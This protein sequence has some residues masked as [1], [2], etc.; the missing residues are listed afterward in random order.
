LGRVSVRK[1]LLEEIN[2]S[3]GA[4]QE[5]DKHC[6]DVTYIIGRLSFLV[7]YIHHSIVPDTE[8][9]CKEADSIQQKLLEWFEALPEEIHS[10]VTR[11]ARGYNI[12]LAM[13][14]YR[15]A[16]II[17]DQILS[18]RRTEHQ[19]IE[20]IPRLIDDT[21]NSISFLRECTQGPSSS[22]IVFSFALLWPL[23]TL[24]ALECEIGRKARE[25]LHSFSRERGIGQG[26]LLCP[27]SPEMKVAT[28]EFYWGFK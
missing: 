14:S 27:N 10:N 1:E 16:R 26:L 25:Y 20:D 24:A 19:T 23:L 8:Y 21:W 7:A 17:V 9:I 18:R 4:Q 15:C 2:I 3:L 22:I 6:D 13:N 12:C 28:F 11:S 5:T